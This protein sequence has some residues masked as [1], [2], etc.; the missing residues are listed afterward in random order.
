M[1]QYDIGH[2]VSDVWNCKECKQHISSV[3]WTAYQLELQISIQKKATGK[4]THTHKHPPPPHHLHKHTPSRMDPP[5]KNGNA[6]FTTVPVLL[7]QVAVTGFKWVR[8]ARFILEQKYP[9]LG[10]EKLFW[11]LRGG[12]APWIRQGVQRSCPP[13]VSTLFIPLIVN[14]LVLNLFNCFPVLELCK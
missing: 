13:P 9:D 3:H 7:S 11:N 2:S 8:G 4:H 12:Y 1:I 10:I 5:L 14:F 6:R